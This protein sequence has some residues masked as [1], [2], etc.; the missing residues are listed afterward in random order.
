MNHKIFINQYS[1]L[2]APDAFW[3]WI[4]CCIC[5]KSASVL[6][7]SSWPWALL[8]GWVAPLVLPCSALVCWWTNQLKSCPIPGTLPCQT[9][10]AYEIW[11]ARFLPSLSPKPSSAA[12]VATCSSACLAN[13]NG[14]QMS[15][16]SPKSAGLTVVGSFRGALYLSLD[17]LE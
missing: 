5:S 10:I 14:P 17:A 2:G 9:M 4:S 6:V 7:M 12:R 11:A 8:M 16:S 3:S 1:I 13:Q 15:S